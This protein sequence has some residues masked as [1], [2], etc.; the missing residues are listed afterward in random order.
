MDYYSFFEKLQKADSRIKF[1]RN[2]NTMLC[3]EIKIPKFYQFLNPINVEFEFNDGVIKLEPFE[4]LRTLNEEYQY[5]TADCI[6]ATCNGD[7]IYIRDEKIFTC[8]HGS[9][10][11]VEE[12][13]AESVDELFEQVCKTL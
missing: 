5:V 11:T 10:Y 8:V 4:N 6:F 3:K 7:P 12:K 13:L 2:D 9:K 1:T